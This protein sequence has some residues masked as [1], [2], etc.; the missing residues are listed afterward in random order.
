MHF[1]RKRERKKNV[2]VREECAQLLGSLG[3]EASQMLI[4]GLQRPQ[5]RLGAA[6][7]GQLQA[8]CRMFIGVQVPL[9]STPGI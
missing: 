9:R 8:T 4:Q 3:I 2:T 5:S 7:E 6:S 1:I